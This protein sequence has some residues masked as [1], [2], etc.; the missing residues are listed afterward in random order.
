MLTATTAALAA[1]IFVAYGVQTATGFGA[2]LI[3]VTLGAHIAGVADIV[4]LIL[5]LS[6]VQCG[7]IAVRYRGAID[8]RLLGRWIIPVMGAG[9]AIGA[10]IA[11]YLDSETLRRVLGGLILVLS[12]AELFASIRR[13][14]AP[15]KPITAPATAAG[16]LGA[17]LMHGVYAAGGPLLV[18]TV[19]RRN[20]DKAAFRTTITTVWL[21]LNL[22]LVAYHGAVG[23][24]RPD[25]LKVLALVAPA[26][27][28]GVVAG[29]LVFRRIEGPRFMQVVFALLAA[30]A[31]GL[32]LR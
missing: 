18:Y 5:A 27:L 9:T 19:G 15:A 17:G 6:L 20:L 29:E 30:A 3:S 1:V 12:L 13:A 7:Y 26:M 22:A 32:L 31:C 24:Y 10:Y 2:A 16:L 25:L 21:I 23:N 4:L 8:W 28:L 11:G 14:H